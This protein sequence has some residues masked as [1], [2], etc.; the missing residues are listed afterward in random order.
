MSER[1]RKKGG[2]K[3]GGRE[4]ER[5]RTIGTCIFVCVFQLIAMGWT[6]ILLCK[7]LFYTKLHVHWMYVYIYIYTIIDLDVHKA[8]R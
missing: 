2:E 8:R 7:W 1:E 6:C 4:R 5:E 3:W